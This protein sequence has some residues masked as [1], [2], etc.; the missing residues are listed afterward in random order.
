M[1]ALLEQAATCKA[2]FYPWKTRFFVIC[3]NYSSGS[4]KT[5]GVLS[6]HGCRCEVKLACAIQVQ[7]FFL[8][9]VPHGLSFVSNASAAA[10]YPLTRENE[11]KS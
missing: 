10:Y 7:M 11:T 9:L 5:T 2:V 3:E 1:R 6:Y 4:K 8:E